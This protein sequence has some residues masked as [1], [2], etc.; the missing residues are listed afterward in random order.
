MGS[1]RSRRQVLGLL[2][3]TAVSASAVACGRRDAGAAGGLRMMT[4]DP[5]PSAALL[6][7]QLE[8][9]TRQG[10]AAVGL[11]TLPGSGA[12]VYPDKL[13]TELLGGSGP[14]VFRIWGGEIGAPFTRAGQVAPLDAY[15]ERYGWRRIVDA[16]AIAGQ[17]YD[18]VVYGLPLW[19]AALCAWYDKAAFAE[20]GVGVPRTYAELEVANAALVRAGIVPLGVGG[21]FGW[22]VMRLFEY[23][24]E[25]TAGPGLHDALLAGRAGWNMP[26]VVAAFRR[27][28]TWQDEGW[29]PYGVLG[30]EPDVTETGFIRGEHAYTI[31]SSWRE[32]DVME[33]PDPERYGVFSL[34]TDHTPQRHSGFVEGLMIS[35]TSPRKDE[36]AQLLDYLV[37]P[38]VQRALENTRSPVIG[39]EPAPDAWPLSAEIARMAR[40][41]PFYTIQDQAFSKYA[42]DSYF[43]VQSDV[44][45]ANVTPEEAAEQMQDIVADWAAK[46]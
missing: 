35:A 31:T 14:D 23:L 37:Q 20:A 34:P 29:L 5:N 44:L 40:S 22:H 27:F 11:D 1:L 36:A 24:L 41:Q 8:E 15:Y 32:A 45:Q 28:A 25:S 9:F 26:E 12:A 3:M 7:T 33:S 30:M 13:R 4:Y 42:S 38:D 39:A 21:K 17:T 18:G 19:T 6:R 10:G 46:R 16:N 2:G 43:V